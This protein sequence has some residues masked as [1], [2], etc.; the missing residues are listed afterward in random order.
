MSV[1]SFV[2]AVSC[3]RDTQDSRVKRSRFALNGATR[4]VEFKDDPNQFTVDVERE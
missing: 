3:A 1:R 2:R 4:H